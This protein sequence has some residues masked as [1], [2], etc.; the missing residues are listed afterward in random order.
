MCEHS[1]LFLTR[2]GG[3]FEKGFLHRGSAERL[4]IFVHVCH[5]RKMRFE[6]IYEFER[7][8]HL[9]TTSIKGANIASTWPQSLILVC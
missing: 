2:S 5:G 4:S 7:T 9:A 6:K 1:Q 8:R 3:E